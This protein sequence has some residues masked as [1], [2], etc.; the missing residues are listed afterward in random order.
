[1]FDVWRKV[2]EFCSDL[3][4]RRNLGD[5]LHNWCKMC[6]RYVLVSEEFLELASFG[7]TASKELKLGNDDEK[8]GESFKLHVQDCIGY[9]TAVSGAIL[10]SFSQ[11]S[12][13]TKVCC[14]LSGSAFAS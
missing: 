14:V 9:W 3:H 11:K 2:A 8:Y 10:T 7:A 6:C 1:M 13:M 12:T 5:C 4:M